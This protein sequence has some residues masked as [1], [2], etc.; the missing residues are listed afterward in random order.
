MMLAHFGKISYY[1]REKNYS[2]T[3]AFMGV[4]IFGERIPDRKLIMLKKLTERFT[5]MNLNG[6]PVPKQNFPKYLRKHTNRKRLKLYTGITFGNG[7]NHTLTKKSK[8]I[9]ELKC[10]YCKM[11]LCIYV[12]KYFCMIVSIIG[13]KPIFALEK[14]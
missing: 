7:C 11:F 12:N 5:H 9:F 14:T 10:F 4:L 3:M 13:L 2:V 6:I 1:R 8:N